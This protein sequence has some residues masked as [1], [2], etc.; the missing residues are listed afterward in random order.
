MMSPRF[1]AT[2]IV[3]AP[4]PLVFIDTGVENIEQLIEGVISTAE[5]FR[6]EKTADGVE[7]ITQVLQQRLNVGSVH[8]I[9]HGSPGCLY[10][11]DGELSLDTLNRYKPQLRRWGVDNI[12]LYGC[13]VAAGDA[14]EEFIA[15]LR[16]LTGADIAASK[17][18][19]GAALKGGN[20][21][22]EVRTGEVEL[23]QVLTGEVVAS[24]QGVLMPGELIP[25]L[26]KDINPGTGNSNPSNF[27]VFN[28]TLYFTANDGTNGYELWKSDG[29]QAG[30]VLL[31]D[32]NPGTGNSSPSNFTVFNDTLYFQANDG[33]NGT[34]L[35]KSDG[36]E[37]G[38]VLVKDINPGTR[39]S[40]PSN[41][42]VVNDTLYFSAY[43]DTKG[44]ELWKLIPNDINES[45]TDLT[46]D[47][48]SID[49]NVAP[50]TAVGSFTTTDP[51]TGDTFTYELVA[52]TGDTDNAAF[53]VSGD[54]LLINNSPDFETQ[55]IYNIRVRTTDSGGLTYEKELTININDINEPPTNLTLDNTSIDENVAPGT[56]VGSFTTT[57]PDTGDTFTYELVAGAGDTDNAA[58]SVSGDQLLINNSPDFETQSIY[59]IRVRTTDSGGLTYDRELTINV[60][61]EP[62]YATEGNDIIRGTDG[63][64]II[65]GLGGSDRL[66]GNG[67]DDYI[68]GEEGDD[69][70]Y[71]GDGND[72]LIGG[73]G[74][75]RLYGEAGDDLLDGGE[76]NDILWGGDGNDT[77]I[78]GPGS[79]RLYGGPGNDLFILQEGMG[80]DIIYNF[81]DGTNQI[82]VLNAGG[83]TLSFSDLEISDRS[84]STLIQYEGATLA[85]LQRFIGI[86]ESHFV[87][88]GGEYER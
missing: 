37:A 45:P 15:Q 41:F 72:T 1:D 49:E 55:S 21:E 60:N 27:T 87:A 25:V 62:I 23:A 40:F 58:F 11:G 77:L 50:G 9:S 10:L 16:Q 5:V 29:T 34:E 48:T 63:P 81:G 2:K 80:S 32:I 79:D 46:L 68:D 86:N 51:D 78:G 8:I 85:T 28:D 59:N 52:G 88:A 31:K 14:G 38:T 56:A 44:T 71:G 20:W 54:Q 47:N 39:N 36:T 67:G 75:D 76:G 7:Q 84:G 17:S 35:W 43:D 69:L 53:S 3:S 19:T 12:L 26:F 33:T 13:R 82:Q 83:Q 64:N 30:T 73:P 18:L 70:L 24:Y 61:I 66:Y 6:I 42:T 65:Y 74:S 4:T 57:D 22:L